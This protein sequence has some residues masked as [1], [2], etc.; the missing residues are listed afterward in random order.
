M[1]YAGLKGEFE[2]EKATVGLEY[3]SVNMEIFK[4]KEGGKQKQDEKRNNAAVFCE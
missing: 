4:G 2:R 1:Y 3:K